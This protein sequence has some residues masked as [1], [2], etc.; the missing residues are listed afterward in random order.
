[1]IPTKEFCKTIH[2]GQKK[3]LRAFD[4]K[5]ARF[6][7]LNWAR[8]HRKTTTAINILSKEAVKNPNS[9]YLYVGP[10]YKQAK[11]IIWRDP[12]MLSKWKAKEYIE[13]KVEQEL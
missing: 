9:V 2:T 12:N 5:E 1:M 11:N 3:V 10:T 8:R 4:R 7:I 13:K 6:F